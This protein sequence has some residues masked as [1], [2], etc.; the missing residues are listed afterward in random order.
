M[1]ECHVPIESC[2]TQL[3]AYIFIHEVIQSAIGQRADGLR[4]VLLA[5]E[6]FCSVAILKDFVAN[7]LSV[8]TSYSDRHSS[9]Q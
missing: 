7:F 6:I 5:M 3:S 8:F 1:R 2:V 4:A 9:I